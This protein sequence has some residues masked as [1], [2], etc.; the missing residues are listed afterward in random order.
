MKECPTCHRP[1]ERRQGR[2]CHA[3]GRPIKR[4]HKWHCEGDHNVHDDCA[5]PEMNLAVETPLLAIS[6]TNDDAS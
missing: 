2:T 5:N 1:F 6:E 3:C 4:N